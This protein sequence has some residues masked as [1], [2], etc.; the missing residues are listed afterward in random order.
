MKYFPNFHA[1]R[2][3]TLAA[4]AAWS[5][6]C[7]TSA[8]SRNMQHGK[9]F[10]LIIDFSLFERSFCSGGCDRIF[11]VVLWDVAQKTGICSSN[12]VI[13][14]VS[15]WKI[16]NSIC[17]LK[18]GKKTSLQNSATCRPAKELDAP[19][20][21]AGPSTRRRTSGVSLPLIWRKVSHLLHLKFMTFCKLVLQFARTPIHP[22]SP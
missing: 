14:R 6:L 3:Q 12:G 4:L 16:L 2:T 1:E 11:L 22:G 15:S 18:K 13:V 8:L 17:R 9:R 19:R 21:A 5:Y 7:D 10:Y 20:P